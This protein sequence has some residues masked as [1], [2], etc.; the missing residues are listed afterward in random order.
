MEDDSKEKTK[1]RER[2][3]EGKQEERK[4]RRI[5]GKIRLSSILSKR[6]YC[7]T[8]FIKEGKR[9]GRKGGSRKG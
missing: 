1:R 4:A 7:F 2:K 6:C 5:F 8:P 9:K 3:L